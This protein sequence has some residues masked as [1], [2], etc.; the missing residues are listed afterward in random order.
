MTR[1]LR[2]L[3]TTFEESDFLL[4]VA[5]GCLCLFGTLVVFGAGSFR[6]EAATRAFGPSHFLVKHLL[7]LGL[8]LG[9]LVVLAHVDYRIFR[10]R[11]L[12]WSLLAGGLIAVTL[13]ILLGGEHINRWVGFLG[14]FPVQPLE[15]AKIAVVLFLAERFARLPGD[16]RAALRP[17]SWAL[18]LGPLAL[19]VIL[20]LQPN[21]G[22]V[23]VIALTTLVLLFMAEVPLRWLGGVLGV[24]LAAAVGGFFVISK[25][26]T[27]IT[28]WIQGLL[29]ND[30]AYQ[31]DQ[32]LIG[33]GAGGWRGLGLGNSH[34]KFSF[35]P[36]S[37]TDFVFSILG[38]ELGLLGTW[39]VIGLFIAVAWRGLS[40][41]QRA[42]DPFGRLVA[43][44]L[45][46]LIFI[47]AVANVAMVIG[48]FP[49]MGVPLP[50][51]SYGGSALVTNL[52]ALGILLNIDR[53]GRTYWNWRR[54]WRRS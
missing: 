24:F 51:V 15:V 48:L 28:A 38:E 29:E 22:N 47:Y 45:T 1:N 33:L 19:M 34:N 52:A 10:H 16:P 8:G 31:V 53:G 43:Y 9:A 27:R 4:L 20:A 7:R 35:L 50:F 46:S 18:L 13:P 26:N 23:L 49:V 11:I 39:A 37:H 2:R 5:V 40:I 30:Y 14:L 25:L 6:P 54:R 36:E 41:A 44:G 17:L 12:N 32:S 21:F 42:A 3:L